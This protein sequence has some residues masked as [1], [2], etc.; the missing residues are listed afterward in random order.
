M[1]SWILLPRNKSES[2]KV[3]TKIKILMGKRKG[4]V[5]SKFKSIKHWKI[6]E[7]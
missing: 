7:K 4:W 1:F 5:R 6:E 2:E 3:K